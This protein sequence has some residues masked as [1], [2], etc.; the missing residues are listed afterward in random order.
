VLDPESPRKFVDP[1]GRRRRVLRAI[2]IAGGIVTVGYLSVVLL[3][4]LGAPLP[5]AADLQPLPRVDPADTASSTT[6]PTTAGE[7]TDLFGPLET[8]EPGST[9][10][11][12]T[13]TAPAPVRNPPAS[14]PSTTSDRAKPSGPPGQGKPP[15]TPPGHG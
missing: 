7:L 13:T 10:Q 6:A 8:G 3:A 4:V 11:A 5:G 15:T 2:V 12:R 9:R 14:A 1:P